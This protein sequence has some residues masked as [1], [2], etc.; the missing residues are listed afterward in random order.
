MRIP[1]PDHLEST[2]LSRA[3]RDIP[4]TSRQ[5]GTF[6][7]HRARRKQDR[8]RDTAQKQ[9]GRHVLAVDANSEVQ[10][11]LGAV[12]GFERSNALSARHRFAY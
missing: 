1:E 9:H 7:G 5:S 10:A 12:A 6:A 11:E 3:C 4:A 2:D 8:M